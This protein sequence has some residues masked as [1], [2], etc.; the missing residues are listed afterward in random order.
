MVAAVDDFMDENQDDYM[1]YSSEALS[2]EDSQHSH[3]RPPSIPEKDDGEEEES[4]PLENLVQG[5]NDEFAKTLLTCVRMIESVDDSPALEY[6][7]SRNSHSL[8]LK[9]PSLKCTVEDDGGTVQ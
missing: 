2:E 1:C 5:M 9:Q 8:V 7:L 3:Y 4:N 6:C